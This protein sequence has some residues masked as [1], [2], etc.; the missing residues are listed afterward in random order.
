MKE[1][2]RKRR[3][4]WKIEVQGLTTVCTKWEK[5]VRKGERVARKGQN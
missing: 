2:G 1:T 4:K 5:I 3:E